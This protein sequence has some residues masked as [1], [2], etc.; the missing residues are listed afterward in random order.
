MSTGVYVHGNNIRILGNV[1]QIFESL[2]LS[3]EYLVSAI[4]ELHL[5]AMFKH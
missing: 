3:A 2:I 4:S 5:V 1:V